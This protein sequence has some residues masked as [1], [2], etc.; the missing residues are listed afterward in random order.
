MVLLVKNKI[1]PLSKYHSYLFCCSFIRG[2]THF[3]DSCHKRQCNG[4]YVSKLPK[5]KLPKCLEGNKCPVGGGH[6]PNGDEAALGCSLCRNARDN[7]KEFWFK[8]FVEKIE[9][10]FY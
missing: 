2:T 8:L 5:D 9:Y 3:C 4:D 1:L 6:K 10:P 7:Q